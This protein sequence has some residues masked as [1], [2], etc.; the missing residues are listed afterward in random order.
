MICALPPSLSLPQQSECVHKT[1]K[2]TNK[3]TKQNKI[4]GRQVRGKE[5][6]GWDKV[7]FRIIKLALY[8][9]HTDIRF[10]NPS[11]S[12]MSYTKIISQVSYPSVGLFPY[13]VAISEN[14]VCPARKFPE[15]VLGPHTD[16]KH[17]WLEIWAQPTVS[18]APVLRP[19]GRQVSFQSS[20]MM[21]QVEK[22]SNVLEDSFYETCHIRGCMGT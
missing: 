6:E 11:P 4:K 20:K 10:N 12:S 14:Q 18:R 8:L 9:C 22:K 13:T 19:E 17:P 3:Q 1:S 7:S 15:V 16:V 2:Q 5:K 21:V